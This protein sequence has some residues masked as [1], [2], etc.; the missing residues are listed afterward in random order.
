MA[1]TIE[2]FTEEQRYEMFKQELNTRLNDSLAG[3]TVIDK[4]QGLITKTV[5]ETIDS[6]MK[7]KIVGPMFH[8]EVKTDVTINKETGTVNIDLK[9]RL[10]GKVER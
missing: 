6:M 8:Q 7:D 9:L 5:K 1:Q 4:N 3:I 2:E 10:G